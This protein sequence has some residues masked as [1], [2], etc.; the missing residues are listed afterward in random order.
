LTV[1]AAC[2]GWSASTM[3]SG[4]KSNPAATSPATQSVLDCLIMIVSG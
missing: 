1:V 2:V 3:G 4:E